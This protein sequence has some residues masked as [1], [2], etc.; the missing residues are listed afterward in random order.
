MKLTF[1]GAN[2]QVTGSRYC[3]E[4]AGSRIMIDC[5]MVQERAYLS[6]NWDP[7]PIPASEFDALLLTHIHIDHCGLTPKFVHEGFR[8]GIYATRPTAELA[9]IVLYDSAH[10]QMEDAA[11]KN[12][13]HEKE[14]RRGK[15]PVVPLYTKADVD[16]T[17]PLFQPAAYRSPVKINDAFSVTFHDA[18]HIL[19]SA[20]LEVLATEGDITRRLLFSGDLGQWDKP[21]LRDPTL[22]E[23]ADYVVIESTMAIVNTRMPEI[24]RRNFA[25]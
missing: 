9:E 18:G 5:G 23:E 15:Y 25:T 4:A 1:L 3:L 21:L 14:G 22:L 19:G 13:R 24:P 11:Y 17:L 20:V 7:C 8:G 6:R 12:K 10:I 2:R 16:L